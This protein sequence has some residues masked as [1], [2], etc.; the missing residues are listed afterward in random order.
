VSRQ[1]RSEEAV[2]AGDGGRVPDVSEQRA[3]RIAAAGWLA[4]LVLGLSA[5]WW[6]SNVYIALAVLAGGAVLS[7]TVWCP[8]VRCCRRPRRRL[9]MPEREEVEAVA[10][11][12]Y[13]Q[14]SEFDARH[15]AHAVD[16]IEALDRVRDA[17]DDDEAVCT[18]RVTDPCRCGH[19][20]I[21]HS[22]TDGCVY[23]DCDMRYIPP[24]RSPQSEDHEARFCECWCECWMRHPLCPH[25]GRPRAA[26]SEDHETPRLAK[27]ADWLE[28][29]RR[30][31]DKVIA[32][33]QEVRR[34]SRPSPSRDGTVA[35]EDVEKLAKTLYDVGAW[36]SSGD[37]AGW[38]VVV[39]EIE[40]VL[41]EFGSARAGESNE[42]GNQND[43]RRR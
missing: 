17:R 12:M 16:V 41:A 1:S 8:V 38:E 21:A 9:A 29:D 18:V 4:G 33:A 2:M 14:Y 30:E 32:Y 26:Q 3:E 27:L 28:R 11:A 20:I 39:R 24:A 40:G 42:G 23:C 22:A 31:P 15:K 37:F 36:L 5:A 13:P 7:V 25:C 6:W 35:V 34:L 10:R 19:Q 43:E